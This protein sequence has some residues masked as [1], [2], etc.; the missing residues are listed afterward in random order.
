MRPSFSDRHSRPTQ[1]WVS[2]AIFQ[3]RPSVESPNPS[4][5]QAKTFACQTYLHRPRHPRLGTLST[6]HVAPRGSRIPRNAIVGPA[7]EMYVGRGNPFRSTLFRCEEADP[8]SAT[9]NAGSDV[10]RPDRA[11][12]S[13]A[14]GIR[15]HRRGRPARA[16]IGQPMPSLQT[17]P[18]LI[19]QRDSAKRAPPQQPGHPRP[20]QWFMRERQSER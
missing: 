6:A 8:G 18:S 4:N 17:V 14:H 2:K 20:S 5:L 10:R 12:S 7:S 3:N 16:S 11:P 1:L 13:S 9:V 15:I 19:L